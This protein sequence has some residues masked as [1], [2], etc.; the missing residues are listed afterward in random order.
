VVLHREG[1]QERNIREAY[2]RCAE[3][4]AHALEVAW[5]DDREQLLNVR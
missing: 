1:L 5:H 3:N 2:L 4:F